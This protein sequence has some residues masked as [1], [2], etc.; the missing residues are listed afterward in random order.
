MADFDARQGLDRAS[1]I[2]LWSWSEAD[3][4][5]RSEGSAIRRI[6]WERWHR[7]LAVALGNALRASGDETPLIC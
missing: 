1:L 3:F 5:Q 6:G 7:N 4:L 2:E